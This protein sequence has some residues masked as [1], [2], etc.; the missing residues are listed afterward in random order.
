MKIAESGSEDRPSF[1]NRPQPHKKEG[2]T[3]RVNPCPVCGHNDH[4]TIYPETNSYSSFSGC[5]Q[6][7]S[8]YKFLQEVEGLSENAAF[9]KLHELAGEPLRT[10]KEDFRENKKSAIPQPPTKAEG[11]APGQAANYTAWINELY[12]KQTEKEKAYFIKRGVPNELIDKYKLC[13]ADMED[14]K[15]AILPVWANGEVVFYT[16]RA[17]MKDQ[18]PKYKNARGTAP[19]FNIEYIKTAVKG[20]TIVITEGI[21]DALSI[22][23]EGYK[24]IALGGTQ[25]R[26]AHKG[27][28]GKPGGKG[29]Y[30]L[31]RL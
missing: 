26:E 10:A 30:L 2:K 9:E 29:Y 7:G 31:N 1:L 4:F 25:R 17:L 21:F 3:Y 24:A 19:L 12:H 14:G 13:I 11:K 18:E 5:C 15:R 23:A 8:I 20:E 22:E 27:H 6:G 28:R 16:A